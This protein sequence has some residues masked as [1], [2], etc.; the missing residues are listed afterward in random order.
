MDAEADTDVD[1]AMNKAAARAKRQAA[2]L[3]AI[4]ETTG[5]QDSEGIRVGE[6]RSVSEQVV[7]PERAAM[8]AVVAEVAAVECF[9]P[10]APPAVEA[11]EE[12]EDEMPAIVVPPLPPAPVDAPIIVEP[13]SIARFRQQE[14]A[15]A[16]A[17]AELTPRKRR[18]CGTR[19]G[20][21]SS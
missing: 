17:A 19:S 2:E 8:A 1:E 12:N 5:T 7:D 18:A 6:A 13:A 14:A 4:P 11:K 3:E 20:A 9:A 16:A 10:E 15:D 21:S